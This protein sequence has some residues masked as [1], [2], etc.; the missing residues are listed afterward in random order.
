MIKIERIPPPPEL[1]EDITKEL[2]EKYEQ[3]GTSVWNKGYIKR[4]LLTMSSNKCSYCE[5]LVNEESKYM[6]VEHFYPKNDYPDLV[7]EWSNLLPS[8]KRCN[9]NKLDYD[10]NIEPIINPCDIDPKEHLGMRLYRL[11]GKD[12]IGKNTIDILYLNEMERLVLPRFL[13][14]NQTQDSLDDILNKIT[15]YQQGVT[16]GTRNRNII[17]NGFKNLLKQGMPDKEY[18]ATVSTVLLNDRKYSECKDLLIQLN[19]WD[20]ELIELEITLSN[21]KLETL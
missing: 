10:P 8:C 7:I 21:V 3:D 16:N 12:D 4:D 11:I 17:V 9:V 15:M 5:C 6:E 19:L 1:T 2:R 18:A 20:D 14:G 13:I